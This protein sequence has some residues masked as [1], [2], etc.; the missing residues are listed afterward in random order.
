MEQWT[1]SENLSLLFVN[2][3]LIY[4][5]KFTIKLIYKI[6]RILLEAIQS[7]NMT[8]TTA[9]DEI[10]SNSRSHDYHHYTDRQRVFYLR[11]SI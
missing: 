9:S 3:F 5:L 6:Y 8:A 4:F 1:Y 11:S 2:I 10:L 7:S